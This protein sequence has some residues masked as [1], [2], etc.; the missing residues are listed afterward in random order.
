LR[1]V[2][3]D[4]APARPLRGVNRRST[5]AERV[6][7][8]IAGAAARV[9]DALQQAEGF[10]RGIPQPLGGLGLHLR[11]ASLWLLV[12]FQMISLRK[13]WGP[14]QRGY[15]S[16]QRLDK[17]EALSRVPPLPYQIEADMR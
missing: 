9:N 16:G 13:F 5:A 3:A 7:D 17:V 10:L 1:D 12:R 14:N 2:D 11:R 6:N 15:N 4:P 8:Q